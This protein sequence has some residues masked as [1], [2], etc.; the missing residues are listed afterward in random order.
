MKLE[1]LTVYQMSMEPGE[2]VWGIVIKWE[3][4]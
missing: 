2:E 3:Y 4:F 1:E